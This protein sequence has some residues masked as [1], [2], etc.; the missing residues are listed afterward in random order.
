MMVLSIFVLALLVGC[1]SNSSSAGGTNTTNAPTQG[2]VTMMLSDAANE[3][4]DVIG[5]KDLSIALLPQ[6]GGTPVTVYTAPNP[7]PTINL[8][9]LD[10][11]NEI[12]GNLS[13]PPGTY[14]GAT[15]TISANPGDVA[16]TAASDPEPGFAGTAGATVPMN[17][18]QIQGTSGTAGSLTVPVS[19]T[20]VS[21][22]VVTAGQT[23]PLDLEFDLSHPA[24]IVA[25]TMASGT[26]WAVNLNGIVR[27]HPIKDITRLVLRHIYGSATAVATDGSSF[28]MTKVLPVVPPANPET[29]V[30]SSQSLQILADGTNGTIVYNV[31]GHS[32]STL[33]NF[34]TLTN[35]LVGKFVR[36]AARFQSNGTLVA[37]R[38]WYSSSFQNIWISPEGHVVSVGPSTGSTS[39][40]TVDNEGGTPLVLT[41]NSGTQFY[42]RNPSSGS[43][44]SS[45]IGS[46][47][48]FLSNLVRGFKVHV[49][50]VDPLATPPMVADTVDIEIARF[51]GVLSAAGANNFTVTRTF[52]R[53]ADDYTKV[54]PF[55][56]STSANGN[57]PLTGVAI[58]GFK[59]WF[60]A[61]PT[62]VTSGANAITS[63][64]SIVNGS[65]N[66]GGTIGTLKV[67]GTTYAVWN[68]PANPSGW[69]APWTVLE[70]SPVPLSTVSTGWVTNTSGGT[71]GVTPIVGGNAATVNASRVSGSA[72]LVYQVDRTG[73]VLTISPQDLTSQNGLT[74]VQNHL[75]I[76]GTPVKV[77]GVPQANGSIAAYVIFYYT[78]TVPTS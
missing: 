50:V 61:F 23:V 77:F 47:V 48:S 7:A 9:Q 37:V 69:S 30:A 6:G 32:H 1:S 68:D 19:V 34:S 73:A 21:P 38:V 66:F 26:L 12:L 3:D 20:F 27:H 22:L 29:S 75:Q 52:N 28:T 15:L 54:L 63:F 41:I 71:F 49:S 64:D 8:V 43:A 53:A 59:Y 5:V 51:D 72:T 42:F 16:L 60:F 44:D 45:P 56:K 14:A 25:H 10:Q 58:T 35:T 67:Y 62:L 11:L 74:N 13:V 39:T 46:G 2:T 70:P 36:V 4:W 65:V 33:L 24:M 31:D 55:I 76:L 57:D 17:Q 40:L 78:G 18:I